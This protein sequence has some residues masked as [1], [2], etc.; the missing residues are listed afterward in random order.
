MIEDK[1]IKIDLAE[2]LLKQRKYKKAI[3]VLKDLH[4]NYPDEESILFM[5]SMVYYDNGDTKQAEKYLNVLLERELKRKVFTGFAFDF[6]Y[7]ILF[8]GLSPIS[9]NVAEPGGI[10]PRLAY[11]IL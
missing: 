7:T 10:I 3:T 1:E 6:V 5:L 4:K 2:N 9:N 11:V 8:K